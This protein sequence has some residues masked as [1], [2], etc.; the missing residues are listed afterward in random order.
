VVNKVKAS[1]NSAESIGLDPTPFIIFNGRAFDGNADEATLSA[2]IDMF[3]RV[4]TMIEPI[5]AFECPKMTVDAK[6][7]YTATLTTSKGDIKIQ[8]YA[9]KAPL[10][11]NSF[12]YLAKRGWYNNT[13][14]HR[15]IADFVAQAGDPSGTGMG[16]PG[17][18]FNDE[19]NNGLKY[20]KAGVVGMANAGPN[21]NGS[22]FFITYAALPS[23]DNG[24]TIFGQVI[25]GMDVVTKL[26]A[27][28]PSIGDVNVPLADTIQSVTIEEK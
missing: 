9:D 27:R 2:V 5:R 8:L 13:P 17:Y 26:T 12:I 24:Y 19:V 16:N 22:Q 10:A 4:K 3:R 21:T 20:D 14:F 15:V 1:L 23:L 6:K 28:D 11:V 25:G 18:A 7:T